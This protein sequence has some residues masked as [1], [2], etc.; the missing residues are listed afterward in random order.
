[1]NKEPKFM[2]YALEHCVRLQNMSARRWDR[3]RRVDSNIPTFARR[4]QG[5]RRGCASYDSIW[6]CSL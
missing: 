6:L 2:R 1:M 5:Q 3:G 4:I